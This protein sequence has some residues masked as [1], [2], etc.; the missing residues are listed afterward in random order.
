MEILRFAVV[1]VGMRYGGMAVGFIGALMR[2]P[3]LREPL[4]GMVIAVMRKPLP[5]EQ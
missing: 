3:F 5:E 1:P 2:L 4:A